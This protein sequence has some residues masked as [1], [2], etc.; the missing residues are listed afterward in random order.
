MPH[1]CNDHI[2]CRGGIPSHYAYTRECNLL[3]TVGSAA[4]GTC[5]YVL[6]T[7]RSPCVCI[8]HVCTHLVGSSC[9]LLDL[10]SWC[11][12]IERFSRQYMCCH[13]VNPTKNMLSRAVY[14]IAPALCMALS[15]VTDGGMAHSWN[16]ALDRAFTRVQGSSEW[17]W[18]MCFTTYCRANIRSTASLTVETSSSMC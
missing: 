3:A 8:L 16:V 10:S 17:S 7:S 11:R 2:G 4:H 13:I 12:Y 6:T 9:F 5:I 18:S 15:L 1:G 14:T